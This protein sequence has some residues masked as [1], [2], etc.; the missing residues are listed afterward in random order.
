MTDRSTRDNATSWFRA[1]PLAVQL[2]MVCA[3]VTALVAGSAFVILRIETARTVSN[4][5]VTEVAATQT[6]LGRLQARN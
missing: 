3:L 2:A 6:A 1:R 5:F 4:V